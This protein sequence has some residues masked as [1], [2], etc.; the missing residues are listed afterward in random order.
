MRF[1]PT[2]MGLI[3]QDNLDLGERLTY[4]QCGLG[5]RLQAERNDQTSKVHSLR[6][7]LV[8]QPFDHGLKFWSSRDANRS[9]PPHRSGRAAFSQTRSHGRRDSSFED[10]ERVPWLFPVTL[11]ESSRVQRSFR[12]P[13]VRPWE[14]F[15]F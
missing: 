4:L 5:P 8:N 2:L 3:G 13:A 9:T 14:S 7:R 10:T 6:K 11:T 12:F 1:Q 15:A